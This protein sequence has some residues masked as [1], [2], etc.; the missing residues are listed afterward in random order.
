MIYFRLFE[1]CLF[2]EFFSK[3]IVISYVHVSSYDCRG[4]GLRGRSGHASKR[5]QAI[6]YEIACDI[7]VEKH[8]ATPCRTSS[9]HNAVNLHSGE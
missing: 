2:V 7:A 4:G 8:F 1:T 9:L 5:F 3:L 6:F